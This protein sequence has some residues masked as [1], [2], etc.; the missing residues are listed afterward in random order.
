MDYQSILKIAE[1][2]L[3]GEFDYIIRDIKKSISA[4]S[5]G[6]EIISMVGKYL[7]DLKINNPQAYTLLEKD[8]Q[9]YLRECKR[10]GLDIL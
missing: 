1:I 5:T 9:L 2:K 8:I 7:K 10:Q 4:G 3:N 6:G